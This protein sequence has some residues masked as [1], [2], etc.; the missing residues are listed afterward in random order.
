MLANKSRNVILY[1]NN[2]DNE[3]AVFFSLMVHIPVQSVIRVDMTR[4]LDMK[5]NQ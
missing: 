3:I 1:L 2:Q 4:P 5:T